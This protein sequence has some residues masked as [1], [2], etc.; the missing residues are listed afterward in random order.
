[1]KVASRRWQASFVT[2]AIA[3]HFN[4]SCFSRLDDLGLSTVIERA[5]VLGELRLIVCVESLEGVVVSPRQDAQVT[6]RHPSA[7]AQQ[8]G[9]KFVCDIVAKEEA[10]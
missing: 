6:L 8:S 7:D 5:P 1:L 10:M 4:V 9:D 2:L 3:C